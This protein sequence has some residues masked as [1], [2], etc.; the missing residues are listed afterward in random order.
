MEKIERAGGFIKALDSGWMHQE[1]AKGIME[2]EKKLVEGEWKM[3]GNNCYQIEEEPAKVHAFR[4]DTSVWD[5]AM[6]NLETLRKSRD[7]GMVKEALAELE[8]ACRDEKKNII[9]PT[10]KAVQAYATIGEVGEIFRKV[11]SVW[12]PPLPL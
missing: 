12:N 9:P 10:M 7:N 5:K 1:A 8:E 3:V 4:T 2:R 6:Q 11:F